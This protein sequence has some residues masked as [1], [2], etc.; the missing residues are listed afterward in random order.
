[1]QFFRSRKKWVSYF[2]SDMVISDELMVVA[3]RETETFICSFHYAAVPTTSVSG[4]IDFYFS[5]VFFLNR[6]C[7]VIAHFRFKIL[8]CVCLYKLRVFCFLGHQFAK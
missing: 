6:V 2:L 8:P 7:F 1:M 5:L 4:R 3:K